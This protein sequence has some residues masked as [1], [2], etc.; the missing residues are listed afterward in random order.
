MGPLGVTVAGFAGKLAPTEN[1]GALDRNG[2]EYRGT[3]S[4]M[5]VGW[6][7]LEG[8]FAVRRFSSAV[9]SQQWTIASAGFVV[10]STLGDSGIRAYGRGTYQ[11]AVRVDGQ[12]N[13][14][15]SVAAEV[16]VIA[17]PRGT[18]FVFRASYR[19]ERYDFPDTPIARTEQ[20]DGIALGVGFRLGGSH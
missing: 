18:P 20:F 1:T 15:F 2:G 3:V 4:F 9:G 16:G 11:P 7:G 5:P 8:G 13:P 14:T 12:S 19:L 17:S 10:S 6:I